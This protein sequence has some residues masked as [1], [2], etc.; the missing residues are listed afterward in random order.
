MGTT[1]MG[2]EGASGAWAE[3]QPG[4]YPATLTGYTSL[5]MQS[6]QGG[7]ERERMQFLFDLD[8][9]F[10][11]EGKPVGL[12]VYANL[13]LTPKSSLAKMLGDLNIPWAPGQAFDLDALLGRRC[14]VVV[15]RVDGP[16]GERPQITDILPAGTAGAVR[17]VQPGERDICEVRGCGAEA[18]HYTGGGKPLCESHTGDDL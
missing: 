7:P 4:V 15:K 9:R 14:Q 12:L 3:V 13:T 16:N 2:S 17:P 18:S 11:D 1:V 10:D 8:G 5:G 6:W